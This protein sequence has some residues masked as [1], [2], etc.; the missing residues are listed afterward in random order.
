M[1]KD[2]AQ[3][4]P[5]SAGRIFQQV[6]EALGFELSHIM[7]DGPEEELWLTENAQPA[8][9]AHSLATV[10]ALEE[11]F[12]S[13]AV[14]S[15][16]QV[17]IGHSVGE[18]SAAAVSLTRE[19]ADSEFCSTMLGC[20]ARLLKLR[21]HA[22]QAAAP[23]AS[24]FSMTAVFPLLH[25]HAE[26]VCSDVDVLMKQHGQPAVCDIASVNST[27]QVVFSGE[28]RAVKAAVDIAKE[29]FRARRSSPL[30]VSAPFHCALMQPAQSVVSAEL[31]VIAEVV[32]DRKLSVP[33]ISNA[34]ADA[35]HE[36]TELQSLLVKQV[37]H[38]VLWQS[39]MSK[40]VAMGINQFVEIGP[41]TVLGSLA[42]RAGDA[43]V[44]S[45]GS[46]ESM[47]TFRP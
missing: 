15:N 19:S 9:Y 20:F 44:I 35:I 28:A 34:T 29:R 24:A 39:C 11:R 38:P 33:I 36:F 41:G 7:F 23:A 12:G 10:A 2:L 42:R 16:C 37:T 18:Y 1:G 31:D 5:N 25:R 8:I 26:L 46:I 22:M 43:D 32:A 21:G 3:E 6:D 14:H 45:I 4:H 27:S 30:D 40:A 13:H 17:M 47:D